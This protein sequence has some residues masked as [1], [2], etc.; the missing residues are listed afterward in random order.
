MV[1]EQLSL[2][3]M[4]SRVTELAEEVDAVPIGLALWAEVSTEGG[5]EAKRHHPDPEP[6]RSLPE[7]LDDRP[8]EIARN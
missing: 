1:D 2:Y 8:V 6:T 3:S 7:E 5:V 4:S